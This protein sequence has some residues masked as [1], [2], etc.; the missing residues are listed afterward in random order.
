VIPGTALAISQP[1][2][3]TSLLFGKGWQFM[4]NEAYRPWDPSAPLSRVQDVN[5]R[6]DGNDEVMQ[7]LIG[8]LDLKA[9]DAIIE[10]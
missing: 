5:V 9:L 7:A 1:G 6:V 2:F 8:S 10:R 3:S 4:S